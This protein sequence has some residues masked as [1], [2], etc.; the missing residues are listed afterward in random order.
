MK[1]KSVVSL[2]VLALVALGVLG[3]TGCTEE[4]I[5]EIALASE[6]P[7]TF[8]QG[9]SADVEFENE[10][11]V[12][13]AAEVKAALADTEVDRSDISSAVLNGASYGVS[14]FSHSHDWTIGGRVIVQRMDPSPGPEVT[15]LSYGGVSVRGA[16]G[17]KIPVKL[18]PAGV[19]VINAA[20]DD[21]VNDI[22]SEP[23]LRFVTRNET[24]T[25]AP[26][27]SDEIEFE[28]KVWVG[29]QILA[30]KA[31]EKLDPWP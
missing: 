10:E 20:L 17:A 9:P 31:F 30:P 18:N 25:P 13:L 16:L 3:V 2:L 26:D 24:V 22:S 4:E 12:D 23:V 27:V 6:W 1:K 11:T 28:W 19:D 5:I 8:P 21:F 14:S 15:L 7:R 29:Y